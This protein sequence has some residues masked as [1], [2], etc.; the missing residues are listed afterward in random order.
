M[1][2]K[3][4]RP[5][6]GPKMAVGTWFCCSV[7]LI[8]KK[9]HVCLLEKQ[10]TKISFGIAQNPCHFFFDFDQS[11]FGEKCGNYSKVTLDIPWPNPLVVIVKKRI[12]ITTHPH[13]RD[14]INSLYEKNTKFSLH[15]LTKKKGFSLADFVQFSLL[16]FIVMY[17]LLEMMD[18]QRE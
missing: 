4:I 12:F 11:L 18:K 2:P 8:Y 15:P 17:F 14:Y 3:K 1:E 9:A 5:T 7:F 6:A 16:L 13:N 10:I